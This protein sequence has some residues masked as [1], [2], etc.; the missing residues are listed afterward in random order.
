MASKELELRQKIAEAKAEERTYGQFDE[1]QNI[2]GMNEYLEDVRDK[3]TS[4]PLFSEEKP[5]NRATLKVPCVKI[6]GS[7][8]VSTVAATP[9]VTTPI[10]VSTA[11]MNPAG[12]PF[13]SRNFRIKEKDRREECG[14]PTDTR[15]SCNNKEECTYTFERDPSCVES[16]RPDQDYLDILRKQADL[17]Q[18][19]ATQQPR[20]LL[21][22]HE[23]PMSSGDVMSYS[24][25]MAVFET[26]IGSKVGNSRERLYF[27]DQYTSGKA[28]ELIKVC[29]QT[30]SGDPYKEA[31]RLLK[32]H[33]GDPHKI[34]SA[35]IAKLSSWP[36]VRPNGLV[37]KYATQRNATQYYAIYATQCTQ[38]TQY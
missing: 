37:V 9:P 33:F 12:Q 7:A 21:P 25:F 27:L 28:K 38:Y 22:T 14:T 34:A 35:Y 29:L 36:T 30:R 1:E 11:S 26:L 8:F 23:P 13:V 19:T 32:K 24:E 10:F 16:A 20:S 2:D 15:L 31:R 17:S 6:Q 18:M 5:N 3:L 4:T